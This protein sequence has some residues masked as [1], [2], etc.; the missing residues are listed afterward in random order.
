MVLSVHRVWRFNKVQ[1]VLSYL[2]VAEAA[3]FE[4]MNVTN[5]SHQ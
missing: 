4:F 5:D 2:Y 1:G 3:C